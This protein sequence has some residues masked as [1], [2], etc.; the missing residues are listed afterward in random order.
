MPFLGLKDEMKKG[1]T[2][3][4]DF[5]DDL[6]EALEN[7]KVRKRIREIANEEEKKGLWPR[8]DGDDNKWKKEADRLSQLLEQERTKAAGF[9]KLLDMEREESGNLRKLLESAQAECERLQREQAGLRS[10]VREAETRQG[11]LEEEN[12]ELQREFKK[13]ADTEA[14]YEKCYSRLDR[15]Y[16]LYVRL[17]DRVHEDLSRVLSA[18]SPESFFARGVQWGNIEA[19]WEFMDSCIQ[20]KTYTQETLGTLGEIFDYFFEQYGKMAGTYERLCTEAG[21]E[22]DEKFHKRS[23]DSLVAGRVTQVILQGY[24]GTSNKKIQKSVV[25]I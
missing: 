13:V 5:T 6:L 3:M 19:L 7:K 17:G 21:D 9:G 23:G 11:R 14:Y 4:G 20:R 2:L 16:Q 1:I 22:F 24:R 8:K 12:R 10:Q 18:D 25:K 15:C